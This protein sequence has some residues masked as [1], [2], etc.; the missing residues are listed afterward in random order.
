MKTT[1]IAK[2]GLNQANSE[3][4]RPTGSRVH[5]SKPIEHRH[6]RRKIREQLRRLNWVHSGEEEIFA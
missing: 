1:G 2:I 6:E 5:S 3:E 4:A